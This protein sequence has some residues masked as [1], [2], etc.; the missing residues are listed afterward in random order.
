VAAQS[1]LAWLLAT[2]PDPSLRNGQESVLLAE[3]ASRLSGR[4]RPLILRILAAAY[5]EAGR[6]DEAR[7]T[8][9]QALQAADNQ[10]NVVLSDVLR[11]EIALYEAG[12][13]NH[14]EFR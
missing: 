9:H 6:F 13:P 1:N 10:G 3:Q 4:N 14:K 2:S 11:K 8:A 5:A 7:D 12:R